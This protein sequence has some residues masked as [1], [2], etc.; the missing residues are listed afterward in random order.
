M[1]LTKSPATFQHFMNDIF[2]DMADVFVIVYL[3]DIL[4]F[5]KNI[6]EHRNHVRQVL[7]H[8]RKHHLWVK[9]EKSI[10]HSDWVEFLGF[11]ISGQ[12]VSIDQA[13]SATILTW[14]T[15]HNIKEVQSFLGFANFYHHFILNFSEI[16]TPLTCLTCK[17][18]PFKWEDKQQKAFNELKNAFSS[19]P[20]LTH[21]NPNNPIVVETDASDYV[22]AAILSQI[23]PKDGNIH[24]IA[25]YSR[26]MSPAKLN[27][28]IYDKE[29]LAIYEAFKQW[30]NYLERVP[31]IILVLS[32]HKNLEYFA[33]SKQLTRRQVRWSEHLSGF[34]YIIR[35]RAGRLGT[36]PD[37]KSVV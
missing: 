28:E 12:G 8:L 25:F 31:H 6:S 29:L 27:Y 18:T 10:F 9:P 26:G 2:Q 21:F 4:I 14:P 30:R 34:N 37:R 33:T 5:S 7:A 13:K 15:P 1:G 36:K 22:I 3:D 20:I 35:Y 23:S 19:T 16:V 32:N 11:I 24:P 17:D